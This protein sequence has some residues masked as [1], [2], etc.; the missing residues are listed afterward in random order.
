[1]AG[2]IILSTG[3]EASSCMHY[4][5]QQLPQSRIQAGESMWLRLLLPTRPRRP[6]L[7]SNR[8]FI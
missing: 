4:K 7:M 5:P 3:F 2:T 1:M 8:A 6:S